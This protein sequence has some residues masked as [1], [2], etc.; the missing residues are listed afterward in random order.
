VSSEWWGG[1]GGGGAG[2]AILLE[3]LDLT[4]VERPQHHLVKLDDLRPGP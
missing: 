4:L 1:G 2:G 3:A